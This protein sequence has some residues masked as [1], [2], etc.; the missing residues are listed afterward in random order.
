MSE[1]LASVRHMGLNDK[2]LADVILAA[3]KEQP[4]K[5]KALIDKLSREEELD[6]TDV[7]AVM[8]DL[9]DHG[10]LRVSTDWTLQQPE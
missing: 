5:T 4:M 6:A 9:L 7:R 1:W 10:R 8:W 3:L 2:K